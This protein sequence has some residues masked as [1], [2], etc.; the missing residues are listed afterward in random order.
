MGGPPPG[1]AQILR[2]MMVR[3]GPWVW[4]CAGVVVG[5]GC[6]GVGFVK[7]EGMVMEVRFKGERYEVRWYEVGCGADGNGGGVFRGG[8][9]V[10]HVAL[11]SE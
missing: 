9:S 5:W 2:L 10:V 3:S 7:F 6:F 11:A 1:F 8:V 4:G